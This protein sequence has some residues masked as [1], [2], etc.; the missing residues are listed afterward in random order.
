METL[1][2]VLMMWHKSG[3]PNSLNDAEISKFK[4]K[5]IILILKYIYVF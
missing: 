4:F 5:T 3:G 2:L 1:L